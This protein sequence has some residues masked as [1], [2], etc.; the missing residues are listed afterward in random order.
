MQQRDRSRLRHHQIFPGLSTI[1]LYEE[2]YPLHFFSTLFPTHSSLHY[3]HDNPIPIQQ[4]SPLSLPPPQ[5]PPR[6]TQTRPQR[7]P[8]PHQQI[9]SQLLLNVHEHRHINLLG[10]SQRRFSPHR[11]PLYLATQHSQLGNPR[12]SLQLQLQP[13]SPGA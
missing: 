8:P 2:K 6:P 1:Y 7:S 12:Q 5:P 10:Q 3:Q 13:H 4:H 11:S 9:R